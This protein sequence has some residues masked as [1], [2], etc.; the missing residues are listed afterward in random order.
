MCLI[1]RVRLTGMTFVAEK[2]ATSRHSWLKNQSASSISAA[3]VEK[4]SQGETFAENGSFA[5]TGMGACEAR[6]FFMCSLK[7]RAEEF[8]RN[9]LRVGSG[10]KSNTDPSPPMQ[11]FGLLGP[12]KAPD[13]HAHI[14]HGFSCVNTCHPCSPK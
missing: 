10:R 8:R 7:V 12:Y 1:E 3:A 11:L 13:L 9:M 2:W 4:Q 6:N 5:L 14:W